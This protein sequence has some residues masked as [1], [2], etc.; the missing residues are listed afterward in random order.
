MVQHAYWV[1]SQVSLH[2][3]HSILWLLC[4]WPGGTKRIKRG[5]RTRGFLVVSLPDAEP[6]WQGR[7]E[8]GPRRAEVSKGKSRREENEVD[9][10][11]AVHGR[12]K[13]MLYSRQKSS[14]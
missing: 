7:R 2:P 3:H 10:Q 5:T 4:F 1:Q 11:T 6:T 12:E 14:P 13:Y 8:G 9:I